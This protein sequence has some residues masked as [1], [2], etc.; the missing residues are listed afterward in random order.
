M[1]AK[2]YFKNDWQEES[3]VEASGEDEETHDNDSDQSDE[4]RTHTVQGVKVFFSIFFSVGGD[5]KPRHVNTIIWIYCAIN[6][7]KRCQSP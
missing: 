6:H 4:S 5:Y 1:R 2:K 3:T 7:E